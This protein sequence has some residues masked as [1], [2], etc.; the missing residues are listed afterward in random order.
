MKHYKL[1]RTVHKWLGMIFAIA[2]LNISITGLLLLEKKNFTWIQPA[3]QKGAEGGVGDFITNQQ[4]FEAVF[5]EK[6]ADF[7]TMEDV[8]RI[9]FRPGKRVFKVRS[10]H[11][12]REMQVDAINGK[13]LSIATRNSDHIEAWHDGSAFGGLTYKLLM[14]VFAL[15]TIGLTLTGLYLWLA[16]AAKRRAKQ[17]NGTS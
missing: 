15:V 1:N 16:P 13:I 9:D 5:A 14:P 2:F 7:Q 10:N 12:Y 3:T 17:S 6:H 4:L 8:D 11:N